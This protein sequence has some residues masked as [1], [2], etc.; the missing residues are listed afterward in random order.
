MLSKLATL[1]YIHWVGAEMYP[2]YSI[3]RR[4]FILQECADMGADFRAEQ[5]AEYNGVPFEGHTYT[6]VPFHKGIIY[7][8][9]INVRCKHDSYLI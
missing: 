8:N 2:I 9:T 5:C 4:H 6:W 1:P 7:G 3:D